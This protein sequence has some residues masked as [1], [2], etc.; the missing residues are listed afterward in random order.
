[1]RGPKAPFHC[2]IP[3][4]RVGLARDGGPLQAINNKQSIV[5][6]YY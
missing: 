5:L 3:Y 6:M 1:M 2:A 4:N